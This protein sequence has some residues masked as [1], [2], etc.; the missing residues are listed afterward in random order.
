MML[1]AAMLRR[2]PLRHDAAIIADFFFAAA[3]LR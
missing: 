2:L 1:R 3:A